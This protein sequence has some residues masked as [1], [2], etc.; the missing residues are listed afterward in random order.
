MIAVAAALLLLAESF[1]RDVIWLYRTG[2]GPRTRRAVRLAIT[3]LSVV[4]VWGRP[5]RARPRLAVQPRPLSSASPWKGW[6]WWLSRWCCRPGRDGS[7]PPIAG[8]LF[9]LL[10]LDKILNIA[11]YEEIERA[12]NPVFDWVNIRPAIGVVRDAIGTTLT[13]I[14]LVALWLGIILLVGAITAARFTSPPWLPGIAAARFA[15]SLPSPRSG[16]CARACRCNS[17]GDP[18]RL[19]QRRRAG[20]RAGARLQAALSDPRRFTEATRKHLN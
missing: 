20:R 11:F 2:A 14:V 9:S 18:G 13:N 16:R 17:P 12:F 8:I 6:S 10:T 4:L 3:V 1:G 5:R 7:W 15:G 19:G